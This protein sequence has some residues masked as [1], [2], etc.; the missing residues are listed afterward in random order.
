MSLVDPGRSLTNNMLAWLIA[1][2]LPLHPQPAADEEAIVAG[3]GVQTRIR[4]YE[5]R[6]YQNARWWRNVNRVMVSIGAA[7]IAAIVRTQHRQHG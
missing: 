4:E 6:R 7:I 2:F 1:A 5:A 3:P